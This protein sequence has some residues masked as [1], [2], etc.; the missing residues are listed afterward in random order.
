[1]RGTDSS[2]LFARSSR[3][4]VV[5]RILSISPDSDCNE[6]Y[7]QTKTAKPKGFCLLHCVKSLLFFH[8]LN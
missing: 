3:V 8:Y 2:N 4:V 7:N 1:M 5:S 6:Q